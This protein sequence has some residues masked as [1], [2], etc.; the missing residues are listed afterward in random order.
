VVSADWL[1]NQ[2]KEAIKEFDLMIHKGCMP[3]VVTYS[4]LI[5]GW[6]KTK[7]LNK[8]MYLFGKMVNNGLNPDVVTWRTLIGVFCKA[9]E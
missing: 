3:T 2:M 4:S 9:G 6:C 7:N 8:A 5:R 1:L